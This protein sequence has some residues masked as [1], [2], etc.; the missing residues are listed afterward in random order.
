MPS[1]VNTP[2]TPP[3]VQL[4]DPRTG[5]ISREWYMFFLSL[6]QSAGDSELSL[7]DLQKAPTPP[8]VDEVG[9]LQKRVVELEQE[10]DELLAEIA[11]LEP[12]A[13]APPDSSD[14]VVSPRVLG[15]VIEQ[16]YT[17]VDGASVD[18]NPS[19][20]SIQTWVLGANRTPTATYWQSGQSV[21]LMI[22]DGSA[23]TVTWTTMGVVWVGG[24]APTLATTGET[25]IE[26][27][28]RG[29]TIYGALVGDVA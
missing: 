7:D 28:K 13:T 11:S 1:I 12:L 19:N 10:V 21:T 14:P 23:Y 3:R 2:I 20:G 8:S 26:L 17:I 27:W 9:E 29:S 24:S 5:T 16:E 4:V 6:F 25:V 22:S 15:S 18:I